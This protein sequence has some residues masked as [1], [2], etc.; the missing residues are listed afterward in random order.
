MTRL[1]T[2]GYYGRPGV[3]KT[4]GG[5]DKVVSPS[6]ALSPLEKSNELKKGH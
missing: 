3:V 5:L 1:G 2:M 4:G 6:A